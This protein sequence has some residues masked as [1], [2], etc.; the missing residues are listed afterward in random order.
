MN[1]T[2]TPEARPVHASWDGRSVCRGTYGGPN[3]H[4][5][6]QQDMVTCPGCREAL[7]LE[8]LAPADPAAAE[9][10]LTAYC[11]GTGVSY[12]VTFTGAGADAA[13][14]DYIKTRGA[15]HDFAFADDDANDYTTAPDTFA[16]MFPSCEHG[17]S[18]WLCSGPGHY[19]AG[20]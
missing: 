2:Q 18:E 9:V 16:V 12:A 10:K 8:P 17:L 1:T 6:H 11:C 19:P 5:L 4:P 3:V 14:A 15:S 13:A 20:M 7:Q